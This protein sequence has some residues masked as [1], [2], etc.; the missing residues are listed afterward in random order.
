MNGAVA[1][2]VVLVLL[3]LLTRLTLRAGRGR[4]IARPAR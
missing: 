4:A 3:A 2:T 1:T